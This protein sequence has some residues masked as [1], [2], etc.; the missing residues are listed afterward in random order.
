MTEN[1]A[2]ILRMIQNLIAIGTITDTDH[3][4]ALVKVDVNGRKSQWLPVPGVIG[5]NHRGTNHMR[6]GTQVV[7]ASP[8]GDPSNG[9]ILQ[10]LYSGSLPSVSTDGAVDLVRWEDGTVAKYDTN[11]KT[12]TLNSVG[13]LVLTAAGAIRI[14]AGGKLSLDAEHISA[15]EDS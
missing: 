13:D 11:S 12:M 10:V 3:A 9:V 14:K 7:V 1:T 4:R 5:Q 2:E 15:L 6:K 8:S